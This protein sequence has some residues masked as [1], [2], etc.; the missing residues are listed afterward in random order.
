V[1]SKNDVSIYPV[2]FSNTITIDAKETLAAML[3]NMLGAEIIKQPLNGKTEIQ[4]GHLQPGIYFLK[5]TDATG[6]VIHTQKLVK[7]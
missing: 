1:R 7:E 2:P 5:L 6:T 3:Y 4:T